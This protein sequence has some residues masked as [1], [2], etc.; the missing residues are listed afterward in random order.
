[1]GAG[2]LVHF[3]FNRIGIHRNFDDDVEYVGDVAPEAYAVE[4][5]GG[6]AVVKRDYESRRLGR[7]GAGRPASNPGESLRRLRPRT[8]DYNSA[9]ATR[10]VPATRPRVA[11]I[12]MSSPAS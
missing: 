12:C 11:L 7:S 5:H 3:V 4:I 9:F 10:A 1:M 6:L 2:F 8:A